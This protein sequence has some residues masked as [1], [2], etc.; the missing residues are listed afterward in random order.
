L[1]RRGYRV[2]VLLRRPSD[3]PLETGS[4]IIGDIASPRNMS[5]A[6]ADVDAVVHSAG[7]A[8]AMSG[9]PQDD[10]RVL[11]TEATINLARAAERAESGFCPPSARNAAQAR[12]KS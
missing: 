12:T 7:I 4:A 11:N 3:L 8:H 1:P 2:R 10:Y 5:A 9:V 6:L